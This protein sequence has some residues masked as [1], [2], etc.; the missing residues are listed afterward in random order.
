MEQ[1]GDIVKQHYGAKFLMDGLYFY[2][3][4]FSNFC[5][6][7]NENGKPVLVQADF[8]KAWY[9]LKPGETRKRGFWGWL[10]GK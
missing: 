7:S 5:I 1:Q 4:P 6:T 2:Q 3:L 8:D 9:C 10:F